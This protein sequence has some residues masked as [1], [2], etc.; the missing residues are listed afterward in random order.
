MRMVMKK[1]IAVAVVGV[2]ASNVAIGRDFKNVLEARLGGDHMLIFGAHGSTSNSYIQKAVHVPP[3]LSIGTALNTA[4][5]STDACNFVMEYTHRDAPLYPSNQL[6]SFSNSAL[7]SGTL[8]NYA[9]QPATTYGNP[10]SSEATMGFALVTDNVGLR[11]QIGSGAIYSAAALWT[12]FASGTKIISLSAT[13]PATFIAG[14]N[15][16]IPVGSSVYNT[17]TNKYIGKVASVSGSNVTVAFDS[18]GGFA[19]SIN[20]V[21]YFRA[22]GDRATGYPPYTSGVWHHTIIT[23]NFCAP[24]GQSVTYNDGKPLIPVSGSPAA[25][26]FNVNFSNPGVAGKPGFALDWLWSS[27]YTVASWDLADV[28]IW[29]GV[30]ILNGAHTDIDPVKLQNFGACSSGNY[31]CTSGAW[32]PQNPLFAI[33]AFGNPILEWSGDATTFATN[34]GTG[35]STSILSAAPS[36]FLTDLPFG[37]LQSQT[38]H[39]V[40]WVCAIDSRATPHPTATVAA[41]GGATGTSVT[42]TTTPPTGFII[43]TYAYDVTDGINLGPATGWSGAKVLTFTNSATVSNNAVIQFSPIAPTCGNQ[44]AAGDL[45]VLVNNYGWSSPPGST[46]TCS[47]PQSTGGSAAWTALPSGYLATASYGT[48]LLCTSWSIAN[49]VDAANNP[50]T[51]LSQYLPQISTPSTIT[52]SMHVLIN[53][54]PSAGI[55]GTGITPVMN[56]AT[57]IT[58]NGLTGLT[59]TNDL[60][61]ALFTNANVQ[62][63]PATT[64]FLCPAGMTQRFSEFQIVQVTQPEILICDHQLSSASPISAKTTVGTGTTYVGGGLMFGIQ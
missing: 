22:D 57:T 2:F 29:T 38:V 33:A 17:T 24:N 47:A 18:G 51:A 14:Q 13:P 11:V 63:E 1:A 58:T 26:P 36:N 3:N 60:L 27:G 32:V 45:L 55:D 53:Y 6:Y 7:W 62:K 37:M 64:G 25:L 61:V 15:G 42:L 59:K 16:G 21:L 48:E 8:S 31:P 28:L 54:G 20:D 4:L 41:A 19:G 39:G 35:A 56:N 52:K 50:G 12:S 43:G 46:P 40:K 9:F 30:D 23:G 49:A 5:T 10:S 34:Q 44:V